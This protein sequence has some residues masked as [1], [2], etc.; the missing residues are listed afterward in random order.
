MLAVPT[1]TY[2]EHRALCVCV[3]GGWVLLC[4]NW[5]ILQITFLSLK[6]HMLQSSGVS[7]FLVFLVLFLGFLLTLSSDI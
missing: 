7:D 6:E 2:L 5:I 4:F 3:S 1:C